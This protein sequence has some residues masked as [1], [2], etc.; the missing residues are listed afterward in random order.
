[1]DKIEIKVTVGNRMGLHARPAGCIAAIMA[2]YPGAEVMLGRPD[3]WANAA[4]CRSV[5]SLMILAAGQGTELLLTGSGDGAAEA[6]KRIVAC[7][8]A[9][10]DEG[11]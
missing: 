3:D 4:D 7:F 2:D 10:F 1:M 5:L 9:N 6:V 8:A 11:Q